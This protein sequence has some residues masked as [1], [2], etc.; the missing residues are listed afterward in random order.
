MLPVCFPDVPLGL[1]SFV[2]QRTNTP[3]ATVYKYDYLVKHKNTISLSFNFGKTKTLKFSLFN[4]RGGGGRLQPCQQTLI[5]CE[6]DTDAA[7]L[8]PR[9]Q[10]GDT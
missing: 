7:T 6:G 9:Q 10:C 4:V 5:T 1:A 2:H 3:L 8:S